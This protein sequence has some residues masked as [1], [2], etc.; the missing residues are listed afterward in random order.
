MGDNKTLQLVSTIK[1]KCR[2]CYTCVRECPAKA[3]RVAGG[4]AEVISERCIGC[5]NCVKVCSQH[6]KKV[7][8]SVPYINDLIKSDNK[9]AACIAPSFPAEFSE[10]AYDIFVGILR[11]LGFDYVVEVAYGADL[12]AKEYKNILSSNK[13][14]RL[15]TTPCPAIVSYIEKYYPKLV[16]NLAPVVS[17]MIAMAKVV[18]KKYGKDVK[19]IFI[20]P[21][22][23]K[24][25]EACKFDDDILVDA[26][27]TFSELREIINDAKIDI[28]N[29]KPSDF[30]PP[31]PGKGIIFPIGGGLLQAAD[32]NEDLIQ[33]NIVS[34]EGTRNFI[35]AIREFDNGDFT[36]DLLDILC[37]EGCIMG[38][39]FTTKMPKY[40]RHA[41]VSDYAKKRINNRNAENNDEDIYDEIDLNI[42]FKGDDKRIN[43]PSTEVVKKILEKMGK[44]KPEDELNCGACGYETCLDHAIAIHKGL[45]ESEMCLPYAIEKFKETAKE[46]SDSYKQLENAQTALIQS[47]KLASMGQLAAGIAH[48]INNPLGIVL[49]YAHLLLDKCEKDSQMYKDLKMIAEQSDRCKKIVGGLLNFAR[50]N[51]VVF[52]KA[53]INELISRCIKA[54]SHVGNIEIIIE[55]NHEEI[56]ADIDIDQI[57][58]VLINLLT[59][60]IEAMHGGGKIWIKT[61][62]EN[63]GIII[64][65][66]DSGIGIKEDQLKMIFEPFF[67]TKQMGKGTGLGLA[68]TYGIIKMHRG[69]IEVASNADPNKG[70][71]GTTF[72]VY[73]PKTQ[74]EN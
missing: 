12:V 52:K 62:Y 42:V 38:P 31:I 36:A 18:L 72:K 37:C 54:V 25:N 8:T 69:N 68:V 58:Q 1:E 6:A 23:A 29:I 13:H 59:N 30:D 11:K 50:K 67:T 39:G 5:G 33:N 64:C 56:Y 44:N 22:I 66:S 4:Q 26:V 60:S 27:I 49:L 45:A 35:E 51:K 20:G 41:I 53:N 24:K 40:K 46:L 43:A 14:K 9:V 73:I 7:Q 3:I 28:N 55:K 48:E 61:Y 63:N 34:T 15:I 47:E 65:I 32:L 71:T 70:P 10:Y 57:M 74:V 17:P 2:V 19:I 16:D 21:C